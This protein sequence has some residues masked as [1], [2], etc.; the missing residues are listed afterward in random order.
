VFRFDGAVTGERDAEPWALEDDV[1]KTERWA[2]RCWQLIRVDE[3]WGEVVLD[4][5]ELASTPADDVVGPLTVVLRDQ[6]TPTSGGETV[7]ALLQRWRDTEDGLCD[8]FHRADEPLAMF[9]MFQG[10][11]SVIASVHELG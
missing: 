6:V 5:V 10:S 7:G 11:D 4:A 9:A 1:P 3:R 8:V 2:W